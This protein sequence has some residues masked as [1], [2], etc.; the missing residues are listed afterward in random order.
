[1]TV[2]D[3]LHIVC[4][5]CHKTN[6]VAQAAMGSAPHCGSCHQALFTG[7]PVQLDADSFAKH[8]GRSHIPVVVD[9]WAPWCGYCRR[10]AP[11]VEALADELDGR[12][13]VAGVNVDDAPDVAARFGVNTIPTLLLFKD[14]RLLGRPFVGPRSQ[15]DIREYLSANGVL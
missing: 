14:G 8:E 6:R 7:E 9:F 4:P 13:R 2:M 11:A 10:I 1:M 3:P 5:H 12:I 15:A